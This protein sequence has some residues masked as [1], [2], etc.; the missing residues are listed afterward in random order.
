MKI[1]L[2]GGAFDPPHVGHVMAVA[3]ALAVGGFDEV[4]VLPTF[5]HAF[6]KDADMVPFEHRFAMCRSAFCHLYGVVVSDAEW[7]YNNRYTIDLVTLFLDKWKNQPHTFTLIMGS[8][9][10]AVAPKWHRWKELCAMVPMFIIP[11]SGS[12]PTGTPVTFAL[13]AI[14]S[15]GIRNYLAADNVDAARPELPALVLHY[16]LEHGLYVKKLTEI[17]GPLGQQHLGGLVFMRVG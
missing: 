7:H 13:P 5:K 15:T 1:G 16:I 11:R 12:A 17:K 4:W 10:L 8:D 6:E 2:Y 14:S 3:Y 9:N